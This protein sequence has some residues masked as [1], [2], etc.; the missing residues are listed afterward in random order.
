[1]SLSTFAHIGRVDDS[2]LFLSGLREITALP[3]AGGASTR[4]YESAADSVYNFWL[5]GNDLAVWRQGSVDIMPKTGGSISTTDVEVTLWNGTLDPDIKTLY[6]FD[7]VL[8]EPE[9]VYAATFFRQDVGT[10]TI[11][12]VAEVPLGS[13]D[14][15]K[16]TSDFIYFSDAEGD[17][18]DDPPPEATTGDKLYRVPVAGGAPEEL[19]VNGAF[20]IDLVGARG[21]ALFFVGGPRPL[22]EAADDKVLYRISTAGGTPEQLVDRTT[23]E[24]SSAVSWGGVHF[25]NLSD[26]AIVCHL[27][28][29][30]SVAEA[31]AV[32]HLFHI[33]DP[34]QVGTAVANE[35]AIYQVTDVNAGAGTYQVLRFPLK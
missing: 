15:W 17:G 28:S 21:N 18:N 11:T 32:T 20:S 34:C 7:N 23:F 27:A 19:P 16:L 12:K 30:F 13:G 22:S 35:D 14:S 8:K 1:V 10:D 25:T 3:L 24:R 2:T 33:T 4:V 9:H 5:R 6:W 26:R 29:C 31:G